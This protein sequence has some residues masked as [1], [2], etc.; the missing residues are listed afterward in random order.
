MDRVKIVEPCKCKAE[1][2]ECDLGF[3]R[4]EEGTCVA[5]EFN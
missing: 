1:D 4:N 5:N 3:T 2:W